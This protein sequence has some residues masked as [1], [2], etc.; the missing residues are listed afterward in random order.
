MK[1][2][3]KEKQETCHSCELCNTQYW[4]VIKYTERIHKYCHYRKVYSRT[5][6]EIPTIFY[7]SCFLQMEMWNPQGREGYT[8]TAQQ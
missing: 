5:Q 1:E 8:S 3:E 2:N 4:R 7:K 6:A